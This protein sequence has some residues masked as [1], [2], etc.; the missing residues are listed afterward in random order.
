MNIKLLT[1]IKEVDYINEVEVEVLV[2]DSP[3]KVIMNTNSIMIK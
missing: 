3:A 2:F 1:P